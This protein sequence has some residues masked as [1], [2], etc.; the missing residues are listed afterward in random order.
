MNG[1]T[2]TGVEKEQKPLFKIQNI[3]TSKW[4]YTLTLI[5]WKSVQIS[6]I[7]IQIL[8][9]LLMCRREHSCV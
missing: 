6:L 2:Y 5:Y 1:G 7:F 4:Q 8:I 9:Q 3:W